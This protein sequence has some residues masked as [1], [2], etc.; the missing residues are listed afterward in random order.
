MTKKKS[1]TETLTLLGSRVLLEEVA[2]KKTEG[3]IILLD[4]KDASELQWKVI[5][6][7]PDVELVKVGQVVAIPQFVGEPITID[8]IDYRLLQSDEEIMG[9]Y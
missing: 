9:V 6:I 7:G 5:S 2:E 3:S 1:S 8:K 4:K